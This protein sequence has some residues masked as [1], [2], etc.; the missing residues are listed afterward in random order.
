MRQ[1]TQTKEDAQLRTA[2]ENMRYGACTPDDISFL[3]SRVAGSGPNAP[4]VSNR[5]FRNV[6]IITA[7]NVQKDIFNEMGANRFARDTNQVLTHFYSVDKISKQAVNRGR[8]KGCEQS[9]LKSISDRIRAALWDATPTTSDHVPGRLGLCI[10]MPVMLRVNDAT[11][12][13]ITKG[14]EAHVV[15]WDATIGEHGENILE[16]LFVRLYKPPRPIKIADLPVNVIPIPRSHT[17]VTCLLPNDS[18]LSVIRQQV[19]ILL[20]FAMTDY[21]SQG[22]SRD[23]NLVELGNCK[24]HLSYYVA[25][26][27]GTS[28]AGTAIMQGFDASKITSGM[29]GYLRQELREL[30]ILDDIT[31]LR[32]EG[33]LPKH[34]TGLYRIPLLRSYQA[35]KGANYELASLHGAIKWRREMGPRVPD[36][37]VYDSWHQTGKKGAQQDSAKRRRSES[38]TASVKT[39]K[40]RA[41][42]SQTAGK[43][44]LMGLRWDSRDFSCAY[45]SLFSILCNLWMDDIILRT[46]QLKSMSDEMGALINGFNQAFGGR[47]TLEHGRDMVRRMLHTKSPEYFPY[48]HSNASVDRLVDHI[49]PSSSNG[50]AITCCARCGFQVGDNV[51]TFGHHVTVTLPPALRCEPGQ[52]VSM[53]KW[54][55]NHFLHKTGSCRRCLDDQVD[56]PLYRKTTLTSVPAVLCL[57]ITSKQIQLDPVL[58]F[59]C[60][61]RRV[62]TKLRGIIYH[63][64][65]HFTSRMFTTDGDIWFHDGITTRSSTRFEGNLKNIA[66]ASLHTYR[67]KDATLAVYAVSV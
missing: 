24:S 7:W 9:S 57:S 63:G 21:G 48:G 27:R 13:C 29:S 44:P 32:F 60:D 15:G 2:L 62:V 56:S 51:Q 58:R 28:A 26:S 25:L 47:Y 4:V 11:E 67:G 35:W 16:T 19:N 53:G 5:L 39:K 40:S 43:L 8:W 52:V 30:E 34:V 18:L 42:Q 1:V 41:D 36:S 46:V 22:K 50:Y 45:D 14:Q 33:V 12:L 20:N 49:F 55:R 3:R 64:D 37:V 17:H 66:L 6:S 31:R 54:I 61:G 23:E 59:N 38:E 65:E 10:G